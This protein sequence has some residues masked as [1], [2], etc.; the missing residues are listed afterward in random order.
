MLNPF[1][2]LHFPLWIFGDDSRLVFRRRDNTG[3]TGAPNFDDDE[4]EE[5]E[6]RRQERELMRRDNRRRRESQIEAINVNPERKQKMRECLSSENSERQN[7]VERLLDGLIQPDQFDNEVNGI[8]QAESSWAGIFERQRLIRKKIQDLQWKAASYME[9]VPRQ[10]S[11]FATLLKKIKK[12]NDR[13]YNLDRSFLVLLHSIT[14]SPENGTTGPLSK[15]AAREIYMVSPQQEFS[16]QQTMKKYKDTIEGVTGGK[17]KFKMLLTLK[18]EEAQIERQFALYCDEADKIIN[19]HLSKVKREAEKEKTLET[20]SQAVGITL[21]PGVEIEFEDADILSILSPKKTLKIAN[22]TWDT[23]KVRDPSGKMVDINGSPIIHI[24]TDA[25]MAQMTLGRFK[26]WVDA[27][28]AVEKV[29]NLDEVNALTGLKKYGLKVSEG[30]EICYLRRNRDS[31]HNLT[32]VPTYVRITEIKDGKIHFNEPVLFRPGLEHVEDYNMRD[33]LTLGEFVK[34]WHR[35]DAEQSVSLQL[36]RDLLVTHNEMENKEY[37]R[38]QSENPPILLEQSEELR[39]PDD[40]GLTF[41]IDKIDASKVILNNGKAYALPEFFH[42][43]KN[44]QVQKV[45]PRKKKD[46]E[47]KAEQA[48]IADIEQ[49]KSADIEG[50]IKENVEGIDRIEKIKENIEERKAGTFW[51]KIKN[52]W[53]TTQFLSM[54]DL[55]NMTKEIGEFIKRKHERRS[56]GRYGEVG[57]HLPWIIGPEFERVKQSAETEEVNKYKEAME[58]WSVE[59]VKR[60]MHESG[61]KD[62]VKACILT[63]LHHGEMRWD[64]PHFWKTLNTLTSRYTLRGGKLHIPTPDLMPPGYSGEDMVDAAMNELW[65]AG[66]ASTWFQENIS[67]YNSNKNNFEY[68]FKNLDGDPKGT[69]GPAGECKRLLKLWLDGGYVNPQDYE[70]MIDGAIKYG[71]MG[72]EDKMFYILAG[73]I[74]R[75]G[76]RLDGETLFS[77]DRPSELDSKYLN[78]FPLLDFFTQGLVY[79]PAIYDK[80]K[81]NGPGK[82]KGGWGKERK[83]QLKDYEHWADRYFPDDIENG[84]PGPGFSRFMWEVQLMNDKVRTRISKGIR[85]AENMDHD[86]A[87]LYI[88]PTTPTEIDGLTTGPTGQKKYFTNSGY[89]NAYPGFNQY[90]ISLSHVL[91]EAKDEETKKERKNALRDTITAFIRYDAI[92]D[93]RL[94]K[95]E[96]DHRARLDDTHFQRAT[97][98]DSSCNLKVHQDQLRNLVLEIGR[99]YGQ[100]WDSWLYGQKTGSIFDAE[101]AKKQAE[102][103]RKLDELKDLIPKLT[104]QDGGAKMMEVIKSARDRANPDDPSVNNAKNVLRGIPTSR[105]PSGDELVALEIKAAHA[106]ERREHERHA[107]HAH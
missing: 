105:R 35:Y 72:A 83:F 48:S 42:W 91:E 44:N 27:V 52:M 81:Y 17:S 6:N 11:N 41:T 98:V 45:P 107:A 86:D 82:P 10:K 25:G 54:K 102:Y 46:E 76:N 31:E 32:T 56:K 2:N 95:K 22:I 8:E 19:N 58:H 73:C 94:F 53:W 51:G 63:L 103:E 40:S 96:G 30:M 79:D 89:A 23:V 70:E 77:L 75:Q 67:K 66:Q 5:L 28:D 1:N 61:S 24:P 3:P 93:N 26:K 34:W 68:K 100:D 18:R 47:L 7:L 29:T 39:Y 15:E 80:K 85:N 43:V 69:G 50:K 106:K 55:W 74:A 104:E 14:T 37:G 92:L 57:S 59:R 9:I 49:L 71:K 65:G 64:D 36:V 87:H 21:A 12:L 38:E 4:D 90:I 78:Q 16:F 60:T 99:A 84:E 62:I 97:V 88:P 101:E 20:A 33:S 13:D